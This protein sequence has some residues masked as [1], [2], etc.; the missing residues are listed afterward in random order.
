MG[1]VSSFKIDGLDLFFNSNDHLPPH[2]HARKPGEWEIRVFF[3]LC[4]KKKGL[5]FN[6]KWPP[7]PD[8]SSKEKSKILQRVLE[9]RVSLL[10]EWENKVSVRENY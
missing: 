8:I 5:V 4:S 7:D 9:H 1:R 3:L 2:F 6:P 10:T